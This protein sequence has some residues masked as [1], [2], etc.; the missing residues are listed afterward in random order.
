MHIIIY[1]IG[2]YIYILILKSFKQLLPYAKDIHN[3]IEKYVNDFLYVQK[4]PIHTS[5]AVFIV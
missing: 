5:A 1:Y 3:N 4:L 2:I